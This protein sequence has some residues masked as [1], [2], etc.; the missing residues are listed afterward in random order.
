M[1]SVHSR[2]SA[3]ELCYCYCDQNLEVIGLFVFLS[4]FC[5]DHVLEPCPAHGSAPGVLVAKVCEAFVFLWILK[6]DSRSL[7]ADLVH[8]NICQ[9]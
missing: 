5:A 1:D 9:T 2:S 7:I 4:G 8:A 6:F 3:V